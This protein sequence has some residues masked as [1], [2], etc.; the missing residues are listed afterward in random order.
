MKR[1]DHFKPFIKNANLLKILS[2]AVMS[3][4][5]SPI[6]RCLIFLTNGLWSGV[7]CMQILCLAQHQTPSPHVLRI[8]KMFMYNI[9]AAECSTKSDDT[10]L[11]Y[12]DVC[13]HYLT[14]KIWKF[15]RMFFLSAGTRRRRVNVDEIYLILEILFSASNVSVKKNKF[16][17]N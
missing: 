4:K 2:L 3:L 8:V 14:R 6:A 1:L 5:L 16:N 10:Y 7:I 12:P 17:V 13:C 11:L 9:S 15:C